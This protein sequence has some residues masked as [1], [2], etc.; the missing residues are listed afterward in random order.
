MNRITI[1]TEEVVSRIAAGEVIERPSF[2]VKE[3]LENAIDAQATNVTIFIVD[4]GLTEITVID[5]GIGMEE[6]DVLLSVHPHATSKITSA[7]D[8]LSIS[9]L[10]FRGEGLASLAAISHLT[11]ESKTKKQN[12]GTKLEMNGSTVVKVTKI[13]MPTGTKVTA[14]RLME[15]IPGRR[16]F[17][18]SARTEFRHIV[19]HVSEMSLIY[20]SIRFTLFHNN[21]EI[22]DFVGERDERLIQVFG[23]PVSKRF[24]YLHQVNPLTKIDFYLSHPENALPS[25]NKLMHFVNNRPVQNNLMTLAVKEAY[26]RLLDPH[27]FPVGFVSIELPIQ[28]VDVNVHPTKREVRFESAEVV[29]KEIKDAIES[30]LAKHNLTFGSTVS[31]ALTNREIAKTLRREVSSLPVSQIREEIPPEEV[32]IIDNTYLVCPHKEGLILFDQHAVHE[33]LLFEAFVD[34]FQKHKTETKVLDSPV[35]MDLTKTQEIILSEHEKVFSRMGFEIESF[36]GK[37][38]KIS[39]I[40][41]LTNEHGIEQHIAEILAYLETSPYPSV[42]NLNNKMLSFLACK[43]AIKAGD[44]LTKA[45]A[46]R[47]ISAL[48]EHNSVYTCPHGRPV[49]RV[50]SVYELKKMFKRV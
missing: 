43:S 27:S 16:K 48:N 5:D 33:A 40:P 29:F 14:L 38:I 35:L 2:A 15:N 24:M 50:L 25:S 41:L 7:D 19:E 13:G 9:S 20:P 32:I 12:T 1:L 11:I 34:S 18:K 17:L 30:V 26:G 47:L 42:D 8:L 37:T 22:I 39:S 46:L 36:G 31:K 23:E 3:L 28:F 49:K 21:K 45:E 4:S 10:G 44:R 6:E